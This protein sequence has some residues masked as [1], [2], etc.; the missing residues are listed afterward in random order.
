MLYFLIKRD[1]IKKN[2]FIWL[3]NGTNIVRN[4]RVNN[5]TLIVEL[6]N[7]PHNIFGYTD[8][9]LYKL[10]I[11]EGWIKGVYRQSSEAVMYFKV[12]K[13]GRSE[14]VCNYGGGRHSD[15]NIYTK[16]YYYKLEGPEFGRNVG[17]IDTRTYLDMENAMNIET[18][19]LVDGPTGVILKE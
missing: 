2:V 13:G 17:V 9:E 12:T 8:I 1:L 14:I 11:Q 19:K 3:D 5:V 18:N 4:V 6:K 16:P 7:A 15:G 10:L